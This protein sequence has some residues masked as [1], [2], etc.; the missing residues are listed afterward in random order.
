[1]PSGEWVDCS[2]DNGILILSSSEQTI[3]T[4]LI[5]IDENN[6]IQTFCLN[7]SYEMVSVKINSGAILIK[8]YTEDGCEYEGY[9]HIS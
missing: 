4:G 9:L 2:Y 8:C 3:I 7:D 1:M 6:L 5:I